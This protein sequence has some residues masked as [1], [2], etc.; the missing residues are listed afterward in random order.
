MKKTCIVTFIISMMA[1][2]VA[3][4]NQFFPEVNKIK[5]DL[6]T[7]LTTSVSSDNGPE[8]SVIDHNPTL[9]NKQVAGR[10]TIEG[11]TK[12]DVVYTAVNG[13]LTK[14]YR[15]NADLETVITGSVSSDNG[16]EY[17]VID[18]NP[19]RYSKQ[20]VGGHTV[21]GWTKDDV[22]YTAVDGTVT[23]AYQ[24]NADLETIITGS[25]S[26][27]NGPEYRVIDHNPTR[28]SKRVVG[29]HTVESWIKGDIVYTA[30]DGTVI[31]N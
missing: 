25:V 3:S 27:D 5:P 10:H 6:E 30:V 18:H 20:V 16:P 19:T 24:V 11:W 14:A 22:V 28:Y 17:S 7:V 13:T 21:E 15:M 8:Y 31:K 26:S 29:S 4:A 1:A 9:Y 12:D 23:N 2:S